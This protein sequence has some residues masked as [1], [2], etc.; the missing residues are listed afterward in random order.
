GKDSAWSLHLLRQNP[1]LEVVGLLTTFNAA[2]DR[3]AMHAVRRELARA[4]AERMALPLWSIDLPWPCPN[5]NY[6]SLMRAACGRAI[7]EGIDAIA[8]GDLFL[9]DIRA[10]RERQLEPFGITPLFPVWEIPTQD[11]AYEMIR[12]GLKA[13]ITCI[14]PA[15]L[16]RSFAGREFD[17]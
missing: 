17:E 10:Y 11:L 16:D 7:D 6:E 5:E 4:Q 8:F 1:E 9:R 15:K 13:R 2:A 14:D 3:V 12:S